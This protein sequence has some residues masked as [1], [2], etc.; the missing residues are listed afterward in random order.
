MAVNAADGKLL[1][2]T[3]LYVAVQRRVAGWWMDRPFS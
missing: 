1:W 3:H 2:E